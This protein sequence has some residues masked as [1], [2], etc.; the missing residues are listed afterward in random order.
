MTGTYEPTRRTALGIG[1]AAGAAA[2]LPLQVK[3]RKGNGMYQLSQYASAD[4]FNADVPKMTSR[5]YTIESSVILAVDLIFVLWAQ[6]D[7]LRREH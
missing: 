3:A 2:L 4:A 7:S 1:L 6:T 5:G